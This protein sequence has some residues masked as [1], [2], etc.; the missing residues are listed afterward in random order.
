MK[1]SIYNFKSI[2]SLINFEVKPLTVISGINSAGKSSFIQ[3]LLLLKQTVELDSSNYPFYLDGE[4][5]KISNYEDILYCKKLENKLSVCFEFNK[6]EIIQTNSTEV[7]I[8]NIHENYSTEIN[9]QFDLSNEKIFIRKFSVHVNLPEGNKNQIIDFNFKERNIYYI[10]T[11]TAFFGEGIWNEI[12]EAPVSFLSFFPLYIEKKENNIIEK[13]FIKVDWVKK[14][15]NSFLNNIS[16]I[17]PLRT[18]PQDEYAISKSQRNVGTRGEFVARILEEYAT[19]STEYCK[20][21]ENENGILYEKETKSLTEAV[22]YW[23]CDFFDVADDIQ[24]IKSND[25][26]KIL[27]INKSGVSTSIKH[28]GFGISQLLPIV[29]EGLRISNS[30]TLILEQPEIHLHPKTQSLLYDF[31]YGLTLQ[32]KTIIIETHSSHFITRMRRRIAEDESN[33]MDNQI[34]LTFIENNIFRTL[35]LDDYGT[36]DYYPEN[37]IEQSNTE[38]RAIIKAQMNKRAKN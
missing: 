4:L 8:F 26:Y 16:Y 27:L 1:I 18:Q 11:N 9:I 14:L 3:L 28:V 25:A 17:G 32:G 22:K 19:K 35:K 13:E 20:I 33:K 36:L 30:G 12:S 2:K 38:L 34:N 7:D 31:L 24:T 29:V 5:Y 10:E 37:F 6:I 23:M 15:L 21:I